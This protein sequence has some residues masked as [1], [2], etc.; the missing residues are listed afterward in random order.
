MAS[1]RPLR[2]TL[3]G[4]LLLGAAF[5]AASQLW[6]YQYQS[7]PAEVPEPSLAGLVGEVVYVV[8][9]DTLDIEIDGQ[10]ERVR[11]IGIDT[12]ETVSR[13]V[14]VQCFGAEASK[15]L[16]GLVPPGSAVKLERGPEARDRYG[17]LLLYVYRQSDGLFVNQWMIEGGFA[18]SVSYAPNDG[19]AVQFD[20]ARDKARAEHRG[21]W[22]ACDGPDQPLQ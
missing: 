3:L 12:P 1:F 2:K 10:I 14:P 17:R 20:R 13:S 7:Q 4:F 18:E 9:G 11:L 6:D 5:L 16:L 22:G 21:L 8:D 19:L 15:A